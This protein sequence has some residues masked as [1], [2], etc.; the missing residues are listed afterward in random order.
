MEY[1]NSTVLKAVLQSGKDE[2]NNFIGALEGKFVA[3]GPSGAP[4][5]GRLDV[6][7]TGR[8]FYSLDSRAIPTPSAW[9]LG[10]RSA[11]Q[12]VNRHLQEHG[13]YPQYLG[14]SVWGTST[15]RTG[16]DDI[17]QAFALM[18]VRPIWSEGSNRVMDIEVIPG[19]QL[20]RPRVDVTLRISGFFRDA[21]PNVARLFDT[22][23]QTLA[24][25]AEPGDTNTIRKHALKEQR[26]LQSS[27]M[28]QTR[29]EIQSRLRVFGSKPGSYGAGLQGLIDEGVWKDGSDLA[30]AY[31]NWGGY[32]YTR[33][34]FGKADFHQF[35]SRLEK[36]QVVIQN[37][38]NREHDLLD[39][40]DYYQFQGGMANAIEVINGAQPVIYHGDHSNPADPKIRT[41]KEELNRVIRSRV[42]NPKWIKAMQKHGYKGAFEMV[43]SVDYIFSYDAT[44]SLI[45]DYQYEAVTNALVLDPD[46]RKF[47]ENSNPNA[48]KEMCERLLEAQQRGLWKNPGDYQTKLT[49]KILEID[50]SLETASE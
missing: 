26:T 2:I 39:S 40:D 22:A 32:S 19:F 25:Y 21:F 41:L 20:G 37:Q 47:M 27:G 12:L 36:L 42:I 18:G 43:A 16:G 35:E 33:E 7:P 8:N 29:A 3:P 28:D 9:D 10:Q 44:T 38:D 11:Q 24:Q 23:V 5:R 14:I 46:N 45:D 4:T 31:V 50:N 13:E 1:I 6:L 34:N 15:M 30:Q 49:D 17:A 48:F